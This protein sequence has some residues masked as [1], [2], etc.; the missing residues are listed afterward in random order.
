[1]TQTAVEAGSPTLSE[2]IAPHLP[3]LRR[4]ARALTG[5]QSSGDAYVVA[6]LE[7]LIADRSMFDGRRGDRVGLYAAFQ[8]LWASTEVDAPVDAGAAVDPLAPSAADGPE[9]V[10][11]ERLERLTPR[12]RQA[13]LLTAVEG[14]SQEDAAAV[15][16]VGADEVGALIDDAVEEL[17]RQTAARVLII[18]DE[19]IIAM[20]IEAIVQELGHTVVDIAATR[21]AAVAA[22]AEHQP[23]LVLADIQL[24][25]GSSGIDA[26]RDILG[27][28]SA[29]VIFI[30]AFPERLLTGA[31]PEPT[32][33]I[34]K[35][36]RAET[37]QAAISQAL[38][39]RRN[40]RVA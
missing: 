35:P 31:R 8:R 16:S 28:L 34:S 9:A 1:M 39:F 37:V 12:S 25:D 33:L 27:E 38:F 15:M 3:L 32:Y 11:R 24:A 26:V 7:A 36:F 22:A 29:P 17:R 10:A 19:P 21:D 14:F 13:L 4:Y 23:E 20:D 30:T 40:A 5:S 2:R 6:L 18:E